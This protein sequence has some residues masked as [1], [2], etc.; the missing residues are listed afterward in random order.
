MNKNQL[1]EMFG[2]T[3]LGAV[4]VLAILVDCFVVFSLVKGWVTWGQMLI[5]VLVLVISH[6]AAWK[7]VSARIAG[8][9]ATRSRL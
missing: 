4:L 9:R 2:N 8:L 7:L 5:P 1:K 3:I 6:R